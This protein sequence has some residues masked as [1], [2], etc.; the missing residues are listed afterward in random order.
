MPSLSNSSLEKLNT[1]HPDLQF[2]M[3]E[4]IKYYDFT[5]LCGVRSDSEQNKLYREGKSKLKGGKSKHNQNPSLA[6]DIVP[7]FLKT[8]HIDWEAIPDFAYLQG[9][10]EA[11]AIRLGIKVRL[12][13]RWDHSK[14]RDNNGLR[15]YVHVEL[16]LV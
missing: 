2:L 14:I 11:T 10:V 1:C 16:L 13:S 6:I 5:V 15:D 3:R 9:F 7:Y 4:V 12:G 8:P